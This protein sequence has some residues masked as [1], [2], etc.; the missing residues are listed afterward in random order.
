VLGFF[1]WPQLHSG[2]QADTGN[3]ALLGSVQELTCRQP[4]S[5]PASR[6]AL[7]S[8]L[9]WWSVRAFVHTG[10]LRHVCPGQEWRSWPRKFIFDAYQGAARL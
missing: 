6:A 4:S 5:W 3:Y 7:R 10:H 8:A 2:S 1:Q 9:W